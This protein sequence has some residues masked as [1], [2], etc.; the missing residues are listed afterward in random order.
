[1][2]EFKGDEEAKAK[3]EKAR[4]SAERDEKGRILQGVESTKKRRAS[5]PKEVRDFITDHS[6]EAAERLLM[7]MRTTTDDKVQLQCIMSILDRTI[8]KP[9]NQ[10][11]ITT[12]ETLTEL[13]RPIIIQNAIEGSHMIEGELIDDNTNT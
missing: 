8:G 11:E 4:L 9:N 3:T 2:K 7:L 12:S 5:R 6:I 1:M 10:V 13:I